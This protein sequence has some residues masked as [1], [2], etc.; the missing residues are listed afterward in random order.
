MKHRKQIKRVVFNLETSFC[1]SRNTRV[2]FS[3]L[4][5][6]DPWVYVCAPEERLLSPGHVTRT[7]VTLGP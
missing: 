3:F 2:F 4:S 6:E 1:Q 7:V 5:T